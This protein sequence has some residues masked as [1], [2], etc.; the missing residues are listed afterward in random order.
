MG[1][2]AVAVDPDGVLCACEDF[3]NAEH[4]IRAVADGDQL[5]GGE[6]RVTEGVSVLNGGVFGCVVLADVD[7]RALELTSCSVLCHAVGCC[8]DLLV[9]GAGSA[10]ADDMFAGTASAFDVFGC[11]RHVNFHSVSELKCCGCAL[12]VQSSCSVLTSVF[13]MPCCQFFESGGR[14]AHGCGAFL[15]AA[16]VSCR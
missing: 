9:D 4:V 1:G 16:E 2:G 7:K 5:S 11:R 3:R 14:F 10:P 12:F 13:L 15:W 6:L 8:R